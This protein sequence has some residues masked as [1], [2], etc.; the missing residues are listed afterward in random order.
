MITIT[1]YLSLLL[2]QID[3]MS[4]GSLYSPYREKGHGR[5]G[6]ERSL[7]P[8]V[9]VLTTA[10]VTTTPEPRMYAS[11]GIDWAKTIQPL[12]LALYI[13]LAALLVLMLI[14][15]FCRM[16]NQLFVVCG[17]DTWF[18]PCFFGAS[19]SDTDCS[20]LSK[21]SDLTNKPASEKNY[22]KLMP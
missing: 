7:A 6:Q 9:T 2:Y 13:M 10:N 5:C 19:A 14:S 12:L 4:A 8:Q 20:L 3:Y 11:N 22:N 15:F 1:F 17:C 16:C 18:R 21:C